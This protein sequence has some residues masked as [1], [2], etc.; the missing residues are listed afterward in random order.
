MFDALDIDYT[1]KTIIF[2][3]IKLQ[4]ENSEVY[5]MTKRELD[6]QKKDL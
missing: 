5:K 1:N 4:E 3:M 6:K 2:D